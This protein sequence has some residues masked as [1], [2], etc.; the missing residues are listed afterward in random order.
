MSVTVNVLYEHDRAGE[1]HG[2]SHIRLL[3]PLGHPTVQA[4]VRLI[5]STQLSPEPAEVVIVE[6]WWKPDI[7]ERDALQL[8]AEVRRRGA[9]LI[10]T[11]DD[12]LLDLGLDEEG[13]FVAE[14]TLRATRYFIREADG[15][16][17]STPALARRLAAL[18]SS[19]A[20]VPNA[21]DE[22]LFKP[23]ERNAVSSGSSASG[24]TTGDALIRIGYMG[25]LTHADDLQVIVEPLRKLLLRHANRVKFEI[26][27]VSS[28]RDRLK[29][30][31][32]SAVT[33][34]EPAGGAHYERFVDWYR[35]KVRWDI[36]LAP[37]STRSF[38]QYKSDIKYLDYGVLGIPGIFSNV[39]PYA[40][41][42]SSGVNGMV[43]ENDVEAWY[44][45][46]EAL[47]LN[48]DIR[49]SIGARAFQQVVAERMLE[50]RA[51]DWVRAINDIGRVANSPKELKGVN[52]E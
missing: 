33:F 15:V 27:G 30:L 28:S 40:D 51:G 43:V 38:N 50:T 49:R 35:A 19:V 34:L 23:T 41:S 26:V 44:Q 46:M 18:N 14:E 6:R 20:I 48:E 13:D 8:V 11:L 31:F 9:L 10:Y 1:A 52:D 17:V 21:L 3:R 22:R 2:C 16:I 37:L 36:G 25:T 12:N 42:V 29:R 32:G 45:A 39:G 5:A 47:V 4:K 7:C 24:A